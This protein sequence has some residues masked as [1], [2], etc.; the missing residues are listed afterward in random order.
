[1]DHRPEARRD[2]LETIG[3]PIH[4]TTAEA[5]RDWLVGNNATQDEVWLMIYK[6]HSETPSVTVDQ[7]VEEALCFG[8]IDS[9]MRPIDDERYALRFSPRRKTGNWS[10]RNKGRVAR[11]IEEGRMTEAGL[12]KIEEA[13]QNGRWEI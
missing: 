8:W 12:A 7:S 2:D 6:K 3:Q 1:L 4:F 9:H 10:E 13:K 5:W 11:L